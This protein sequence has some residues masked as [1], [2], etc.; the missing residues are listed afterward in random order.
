[1]ARMNSNVQT[2]LM[3][4]S[5]VPTKLAIFRVKSEVLSDNRP[6]ADKKMRNMAPGTDI[7]FIFVSVFLPGRGVLSGCI[8]ID[9]K[10]Y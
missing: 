3:M 1:M 4:N 5:F 2:F 10:H 7:F 6:M 9:H 8:L